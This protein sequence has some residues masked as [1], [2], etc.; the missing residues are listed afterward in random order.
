M[1]KC[2]HCGSSAQVRK[3]STYFAW[4]DDALI[5]LYICGCGAQFRAEYKENAEGT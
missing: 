2:P 5:I 3:E 4:E 1:I